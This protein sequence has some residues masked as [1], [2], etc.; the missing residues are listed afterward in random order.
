MCLANSQLILLQDTAY[1]RPYEVLLL[2]KLA[3]SAAQAK[4][5]T[6]GS[7]QDAE[8]GEG[9]LESARVQKQQPHDAQLTESKTWALQSAGPDEPE[10]ISDNQICKPLRD[11]VMIAVPGQHSRK[12]HLD[13]LLAPHLPMQPECLEVVLRPSWL[14]CSCY[15]PFFKNLQ[16]SRLSCEMSVYPRGQSPG[17]DASH[18]YLSTN[19][20]LCVLRFQTKVASQLGGA[21]DVQDICKDLGALQVFARELHAGWTSIGNETLLFQTLDHFTELQ[22]Q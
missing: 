21:A 16:T 11:M 14:S 4:A 8:F 9:V 3:P 12:P 10:S 13:K 18:M 15:P 20:A 17:T 22:P 2:C 7:A 5:P 19:W 6:A 1:R